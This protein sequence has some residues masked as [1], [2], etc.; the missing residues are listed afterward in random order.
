MRHLL[1]GVGFVAA[2]LVALT[3]LAGML[4]T[5]VVLALWSAELVDWL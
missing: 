1:A 3:V 5:G 2:T 4:V